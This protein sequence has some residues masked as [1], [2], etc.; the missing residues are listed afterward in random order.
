MKFEIRLERPSQ[1]FVAD[2]V[3]PTSEFYSEYTIRP[4]ME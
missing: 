1:L 3:P 2:G 4:A